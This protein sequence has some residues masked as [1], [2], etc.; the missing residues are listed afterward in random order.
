MLQELYSTN[1][2]WPK[3]FGPMRSYMLFLTLIGSHHP[4]WVMSHHM[5]YCIIKGQIMMTLKFLGAFV[6]LPL[7]HTID[8]NWIHMQN[9]VHF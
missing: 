6:M 4:F 1:L 8:T 7:S 9:N 5:S 3:Y 2:I